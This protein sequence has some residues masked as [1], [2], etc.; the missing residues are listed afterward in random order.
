[1]RFSSLLV[2]LLV[3]TLFGGCTA[4]QREVIRQRIESIQPR[5]QAAEVAAKDASKDVDTYAAKVEAMED[6]E[7]KKAAATVLAGLEVLRDKALLKLGDVNAELYALNEALA[8]GGDD[9][10][11]AEHVVNAAARYG[12]EPWATLAGLAGTVVFGVLR[13]QEKRRREDAEDA[14][15]EI[16][17]APGTPRAV[18]QA[19]S[20][21]AQ[22]AIRQALQ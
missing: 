15:A 18:E 6:G 7:A 22:R 13:G 4:D 21:R 9:Y 3:C 20:G 14:L 17:F 11:L 5:L 2:V 8:S 19:S 16:D 12:P 1:M 10:T